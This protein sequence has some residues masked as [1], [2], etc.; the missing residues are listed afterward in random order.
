M[1]KSVKRTLDRQTAALNAEAGAAKATDSWLKQRERHIAALERA[2]G[3]VFR[4]QGVPSGVL[5]SYVERTVGLDDAD[6]AE[7]SALAPLDPLPGSETSAAHSSMDSLSLS[8]DTTS[9]ASDL[10]HVHSAMA[11]AHAAMDT[12]ITQLQELASGAKRARR[13]LERGESNGTQGYMAGDRMVLPSPFALALMSATGTPPPP[14]PGKGGAGGLAHATAPAAALWSQ[15]PAMQAFSPPR[16][17]PLA[18][19]NGG[20]GGSRLEG[21][22]T[23]HLQRLRE[24]REANAR[25][26]RTHADWLRDFKGNLRSGLVATRASL[27][28]GLAASSSE[29]VWA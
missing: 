3:D 28:H 22:S 19:R 14:S 9:G 7:L 23:S 5:L 26:M 29:N 13:R 6:V 11:T 4:L 15:S 10:M 16:R 21:S 25:A 1:L 2:L 18:E 24:K 12:L 27:S 20:G 17:N 8:A